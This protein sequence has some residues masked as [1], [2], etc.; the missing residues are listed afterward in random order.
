MLIHPTIQPQLGT[1]AMDQSGSRVVEALWR[2][3]EAFASKSSMSKEMLSLRE[4]I[5]RCLAPLADRLEGAKFGRFVENLVGSAVYRTNPQR[6]RQVKLAGTSVGAA[7]TKENTT[8]GSKSSVKRRQSQP[9]LQKC[10]H[11]AKKQ[12]C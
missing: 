2:S 6:W 3:S 5:A 9:D 12:K 1:L 7:K 8:G 11:W 4:E 10:K